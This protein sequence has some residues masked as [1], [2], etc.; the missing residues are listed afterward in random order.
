MLFRSNRLVSK[1]L[2][3]GAGE[4]YVITLVP[5]LNPR[6]AVKLPFP[7]ARLLEVV[8]LNETQRTS[9]IFTP[10]LEVVI[11]VSP[12]LIFFGIDFRSAR[13]R[14]K[15]ATEKFECVELPEAE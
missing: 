5:Y 11:H 14:T 9:A 12:L 2:W 8:H 10:L 3:E 4:T 7:P 15:L 6:I 13:R 1:A